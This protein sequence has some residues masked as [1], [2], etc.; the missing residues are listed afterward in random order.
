MIRDYMRC[1]HDLLP[2]GFANV[3]RSYFL[4][5]CHFFLF[6][7][8]FILR[9]YS[10]YLVWNYFYTFLLLFPSYCSRPL[11]NVFRCMDCICLGSPQSI[12]LFF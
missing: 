5:G 8:L 1:F 10:D 7:R 6:L 12:I 3:L 4:H 2:F 11:A 9:S